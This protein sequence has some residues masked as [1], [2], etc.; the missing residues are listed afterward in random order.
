MRHPALLLA[1]L[2][3]FTALTPGAQKPDSGTRSADA[4]SL[5]AG[6]FLFEPGAIQPRY[7]D[8]FDSRPIVKSPDGRLAVTVTGPKESY[9]AWVT[10]DPSEFP[11][12]PVQVWPIQRNVDVLWRPDSRMFALTDNRSANASY[13]LLFGIHFRMGEGEGGERLG[14]PITD[15]TPPVQEV[16]EARAQKFY[17]PAAYNTDLVYVKALRWVGNGRLLAGLNAKTSLSNPPGQNRQDIRVKDWYVGYVIDVTS[18]KVVE[19]LSERQLFSQYG[20][21]V[22]K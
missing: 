18:K 8:A 16:F 6:P 10:I 13:L 1:V 14:I 15:L 19:E 22:T 3:A 17:A 20:I 5:A 7:M 9:G 2:L 21:K 11:D 4:D 12:G